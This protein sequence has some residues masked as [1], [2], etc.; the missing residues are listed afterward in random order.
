MAAELEEMD[1]EI[2]KRLDEKDN[3]E[4]QARLRNDTAINININKIKDSSI[5]EK[6]VN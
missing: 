6:Q 2:N 3:M 4:E 1:R 5:L